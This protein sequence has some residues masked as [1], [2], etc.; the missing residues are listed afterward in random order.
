MDRTYVMQQH[1][2]PVF[3]LGLDLWRDQVGDESWESGCS[4]SSGASSR[5]S[6][7]SRAN[8]GAAALAVAAAA[9]AAAV[10]AS[11]WW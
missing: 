9:L 10:C 8:H 3:Q 1:K 7:T 11:R 4:N 6:T 5:R 2:V